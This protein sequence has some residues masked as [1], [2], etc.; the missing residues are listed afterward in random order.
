MM[1]S[2][3]ANRLKDEALSVKYQK[4][5]RNSHCTSQ[6]TKQCF[7]FVRGAIKHPPKNEDHIIQS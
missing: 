4:L 2:Y 1:I 6:S 7:H 5:F 3:L